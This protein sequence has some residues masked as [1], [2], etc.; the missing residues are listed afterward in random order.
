MYQIFITPNILFR[1]YW[2]K[3]TKNPAERKDIPCLQEKRK[4]TARYAQGH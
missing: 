4:V 2:L 1:R 3:E